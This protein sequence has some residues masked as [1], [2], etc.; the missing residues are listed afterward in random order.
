MGK[1]LSYLRGQGEVAQ[2]MGWW[3]E[4]VGV[5]VPYDPLKFL[6]LP[7][8]VEGLMI[9]EVAREI[10]AYQRKVLGKGQQPL[11]RGVVITL[12]GMNPGC[13]LADHL[14]TSM[15]SFNGIHFSLIHCGQVYTN[16]RE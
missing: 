8:E 5:E 9:E 4:P 6:Y 15:N 10:H 7:R 14:Q 16:N 13:L 1:E 11:N 3:K 12:G 2:V